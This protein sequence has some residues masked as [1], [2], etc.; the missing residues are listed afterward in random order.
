M[1][2]SAFALRTWTSADGLT[3]SARDYPGAA[4]AARPPVICIHGLTR[5][6]RDF[7][8]V[9]PR[10]AEETGRRVL[11]IDVRGRGLSD[12]DSNP[13]NYNP[14]V[15]AGDVIA[16][17][18]Q[19]GIGKAAFVGTSMGGL[20]MMVLAMS[21][22]DLIERAVLNDVG[23]EVG[24]AGLARIAGY[25]GGGGTY[26][27]WAEAAAYIK[28]VNG[29][30]LPDLT[31]ADWLTFASRTFRE[32]DGRIE[33]DYDPAISNVFKTPP[34]AD[35]PAP[36]LWPL[37]MAL[38]AGRP[39]MVVRGANSDILEAATVSKMSEAAP[40][41]RTLE[42]PGVG[43][44]PTLEEPAALSGLITFLRDAP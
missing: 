41:L 35:A 27:T 20:I 28:S 42:I 39:A 30:A 8:V 18:A 19:A 37:F 24:A 17:C 23:P 34:P 25:V 14:A 40:H 15:Y 22:P 29:S 4:G 38:T 7:E 36:N 3:L 21:R 12:R 6:A 26:A 2:R 13:M 11:A 33:L 16:L 31:D 43:H 9:A 5:N 1:D 10:L 32:H 44:A